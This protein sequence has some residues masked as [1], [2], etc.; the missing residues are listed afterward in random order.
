MSR[1]T[2]KAL[3][4][5]S[6]RSRLIFSFSAVALLA[7]VSA[8]I[9]MVLTQLSE[10]QTR[11]ILTRT[12]PIV[13]DA[14]GLG[15]TIMLFAAVSKELPV[16][17]DTG[18]YHQLL[19]TMESG[20]G[21]MDKFLGDLNS[22]GLDEASFQE[23]SSMVDALRSNMARQNELALKFLDTRQRLVIA[24]AGLREQ[25]HFFT[26]LVQPRTTAGYRVFVEQSQDIQADI[27]ERLDAAAG[28]GDLRPLRNA[29]RIGFDSL[30]SSAVGEMW[31]NHEI[32]AITFQAYSLLLEAEI[33]RSPEKVTD[34]HYS[35]EQ[36]ATVFERLQLVLA[37]I[38]P[39]RDRVL[40]AALDLYQLGFGPA[41]IFSLRDS[42]LNDRA[43]AARL[44]TESHALAQLF[45]NRAHTLTVRLRETAADDS[46]A[47][48]AMLALA[49]F[50]QLLLIVV[51]VLVSVAIGW[52]YVGRRLISRIMSLKTAMDQHAMG[53]DA[54]IP[55][56]GKDEIT[57]MA[58]ALQCFVRQRTTV[59]S[60]LRQILD[61]LN[62]AQLIANFGSCTW[63]EQ[64]A[65]WQW[66][67]G[68]YRILGFAP[69]EISAGWQEF[70]ER[71]DAA[72][73]EKVQRFFLHLTPSARIFEI[74]FSLRRKDDSRCAVTTRWKYA[75]VGSRITGNL[76][77]TLLDVTERQQIEDELL[78]VRKLE[79]IGVLAGG[80][81]HDFNNLLT[82]IM[83]NTALA[84]R[85]L[86][87]DHAIQNFLRLSDNAANRAR[88][89]TKRLLTFAKGGDPIRSVTDLRAI[90]TEVVEFVLHG[91]NVRCHLDIP[92][93]LWAA[94]VDSGQIGQVF[95]NLVVNADQAMPD[96]GVIKI[97]CRNERIGRDG[98]GALL[99]GD[100]IR[101]DITDQGH[102][103]AREHLKRVFDPYF[104]T[105]E[106][107]SSKG[108]GL[109]LAI[110]HSIIRKHSGAIDVESSPGAGTT[111]TLH[112]PARSGETAVASPPSPALT[113]PQ[114]DTVS[115]GLVLVMDDEEMVR[116]VAG[117]MLEH[118]GYEVLMA[119]D[120][121][122]AIDI[123]RR[124]LSE[125]RPP[126]VV[127]MDLTVPG[128]LGG[129]KAAAGILA[130]DET[131]RI[132][133]SSGYSTNGV[134]ENYQEYGFCGIA[135]KPYRMT[136]LSATI[137]EALAGAPFLDQRR[138]RF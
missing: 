81:A 42:E 10:R 29:F 37:P 11:Q 85:Q 39:E 104:T 137:N 136:E 8:L 50:I 68:F 33:A 122:Q 43:A 127:L 13:A 134:F 135:G 57:D 60:A 98:M 121:G 118:L 44:S 74:D 16:I 46:Q 113:A 125:G 49:G 41:S 100:Y 69:G 102:G 124:C 108:S 48:Q 109:G 120:G 86:P 34:L 84:R 31:A 82:V 65:Q 112:I 130:L 126:D 26:S 107:D 56:E 83:G 70:L 76:H 87:P 95:Q 110:V 73:R 36:L 24:D 63:D 38:T 52:H 5:G 114:D 97:S 61:S 9:G 116:D 75:K 14:Q 27:G 89:L 17:E 66:S 22:L 117:A 106:M 35:Y 55:L 1:L 40:R 15:R 64:T 138:D 132:I 88:D 72:D 12:L 133:V 4:D 7:A 77:G 62:E 51:V 59:E 19:Q 53:M 18:R 79:S 58:H 128:G 67:D 47:L 103:I 21:D 2:K 93:S 54:E 96:G 129:E 6:I 45:A 32:T 91:S 71:V 90:L 78:K 119:D 123:Y 131:A 80:I 30:V 101:I 92:E 25:H 94:D 23:M 111:F 28:S 20:I 105:K 99:A 115:S 3:F